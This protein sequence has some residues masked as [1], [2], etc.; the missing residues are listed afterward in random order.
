M[1][2]PFLGAAHDHGYLVRVDRNVYLANRH[3]SRRC[4]LL[5]GPIFAGTKLLHEVETCDDDAVL[6]SFGPAQPARSYYALMSTG[7]KSSLSWK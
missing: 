2:G 4:E 6:A 7:M 3:S 1:L 5:E